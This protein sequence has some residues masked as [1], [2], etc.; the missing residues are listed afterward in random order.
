MLFLEHFIQVPERDSSLQCSIFDDCEKRQT[1]RERPDGREE[2]GGRERDIA[3][4]ISDA[5]APGSA[6]DQG[7]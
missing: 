7:V 1:G 6:C 5:I 3:G 2:H 4:A